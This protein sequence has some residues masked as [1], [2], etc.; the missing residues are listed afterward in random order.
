MKVY[1]VTQGCYSDYH[2]EKV[3]LDRQKAEE[4]VKYYTASAYDDLQ[5]EEYENSNEMVI[6]PMY[7]ANIEYNILT[8]EYSFKIELSNSEDMRHKNKTD[9][10]FGRSGYNAPI[11]A[12]IIKLFR[13]V[14]SNNDDIAYNKY[15]K[16][17]RD[18]STQIK[19]LAS[20][21]LS[22]NEIYK[23]IV[24]KAME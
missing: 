9:L 21:G 7:Y 2:I 5:I 19:Y 17:C 22:Q 11:S 10:S 6:T 14:S 13:E 20:E 4:Y 8:D 24:N 16:V 18:L 3:F 1:I 12:P 15:L 23:Q